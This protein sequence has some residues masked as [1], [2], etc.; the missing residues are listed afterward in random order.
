MENKVKILHTQIDIGIGRSFR[1]IHISD[2]HLTLVNANDNERKH[3]L[4]QVR[5]KAFPL[6]RAVLETAKNISRKE[7]FPILCTGD[8]IDFVS[9]ANLKAAEIFM[10][11]TNAL[12]VAGNH[13]FSQYVGEA[14]ED[15]A[16]REQSLAKVEK[17]FG[18]DVRFVSRIING[19][20]FVGIDD[21]Y[22]QFDGWQLN[23]LKDEIEK[24]YPVVLL[25][26]VPLFEKALFDRVM[27]NGQSS[28]T[29]IPVCK[30]ADLVGVSEI[31]M[32]DYAPGRKEAQLPTEETMETVNYIEN[33]GRIKALLT[34]HWHFDHVAK[35][36]SD[37]PQIITGCKTVRIVEFI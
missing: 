21:G 33:S 20:N 18:G 1:V 4:C 29:G 25:L 27:Y 31:F 2:T 30:S 10:K 17:A 16:Y 5:Q 19:V 13:E 15:A 36:T 12:F 11:E 23:K 24:G 9:D 3:A 26:H 34:G 8:L 22:Y 35:T 14:K 6:Q 7:G 32:K 28:E 37:I